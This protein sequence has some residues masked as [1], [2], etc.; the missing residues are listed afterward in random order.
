GEAAR[1]AR[2]TGSAVVSLAGSRDGSLVL[3]GGADYR[4]RAYESAT[5]RA[6]GPD[7]YV[8]APLR[9]VALAPD[10]KSFVTGDAFAARLWQLVR[11]AP[12][13]V[14]LRQPPAIR[15]LALSIVPRR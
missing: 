10:G 11:A 9:S 5:G 14:A 4:V 6:V 15:R 12:N 7:L 2:G 8:A 3:T 1:P 13:E